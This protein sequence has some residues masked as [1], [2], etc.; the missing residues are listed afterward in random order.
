M[1]LQ[2]RLEII[3]QKTSTQMLARPING[4][5]LSHKKMGFTSLKDASKESMEN[6]QKIEKAYSIL[7][8]LINR[9]GHAYSAFFEIKYFEAH[10][11]SIF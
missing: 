9:K 10:Y 6:Q 1:K 4:L 3:L 2:Y 8:S 11:G 5:I 7:Q